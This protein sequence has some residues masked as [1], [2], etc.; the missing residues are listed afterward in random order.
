MSWTSSFN[1]WE[2]KVT[3]LSKNLSKLRKHFVQSV[4]FRSKGRVTILSHVLSLL[5]DVEWYVGTGMW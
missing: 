5:N 4:R 3:T 1:K 2:C